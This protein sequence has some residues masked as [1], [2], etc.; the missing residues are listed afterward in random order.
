V[1]CSVVEVVFEAPPAPVPT[2]DAVTVPAGADF[3]V[4]PGATGAIGT[5]IVFVLTA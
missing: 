4:V 1:T 3:K 2:T 5:T